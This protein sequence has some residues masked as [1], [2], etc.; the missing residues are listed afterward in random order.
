MEDEAEGV[1]RTFLIADV[2]GYTRYTQ[3]RGDE[4]AAELAAGFARL[5]RE[6]VN[7]GGG[8]LVELRGDEALAVFTSPRQAVRTA[9]QIQRRLRGGEDPGEALPLGIGIGIDTGEAVPVEDGWR[10]KALNVAARLCSVAQPGQIYVTETTGALA[11]GVPGVQL[12]ARKPVRVKGIEQPVRLLEAVPE[13]PLPPLRPLDETASPRRRIAALAVAGTLVA[14]AIAV[15]VLVLGGAGHAGRLATNS[16]GAVDRSGHVHDVVVAGK[17]PSD[18]V[19]DSGALWVADATGHAL[20]RV[21]PRS[22]TVDNYALGDAQPTA[23]AYGDK[24]VWILDGAARRLLYWVPDP[25][26][27]TGSVRVGNGAADVAF[28][29]GAAWV[30]NQVDGTVTRVDAKTLKTRTIDVGVAPVAATWGKGALWV[31]NAGSDSIS[32]VSADGEVETIAVGH[33]PRAIA[34]GGKS[35]WVTSV[36]DHTVWEI[37]PET[38]SARRTIPVDGRPTAIAAD[39]TG[40]WVAAGQSGTVT[41]IDGGGARAHDVGGGPVALAADGDRVWVAAGAPDASHRGGT[42]QIAGLFPVTDQQFGSPGATINPEL[43][44]GLVGLKRVGGPAGT[45]VVPDLATAIPRASYD[46]LTYTF[47]LRNGIRFSDGTAVDP[48]DFVYTF[49]RLFRLH[50]PGAIGEFYGNLAGADA[51][52]QDRSRCDVS[53]MVTADDKAMTVTFHLARRDPD[54][55]A[56]LTFPL[57]WVLPTG[58]PMRRLETELVPSTGPYK[59]AE[60]VAGK[61]MVLTRNPYFHEW[62]HDAQPEGYP[63]RIVITPSTDAVNQVRADKADA[64]SDVVPA[65][66]VPPLARSFPAR[67]HSDTYSKLLYAFLNTRRAPFDNPKARQAVALALDRRA[68]VNRIGGPLLNPVACQVIPP[69]ILGFR[70]YCP[71]SKDPT[72]G[73]WTGPDLAKAQRLV[74]ESGTRGMHVTVWR[75]VVEEPW[76]TFGIELAATLRRV[77]YRV[78]EHVVPGDRF[79]YFG[80]LLDPKTRAQAGPATWAPDVPI[81]SQAVELLFSCRGPNNLSQYCNRR[82]DA[83]MRAAAASE[84]THPGKSAAQWAQ[85][86]RAIV[87]D[88]PVVPVAILGYAQLVSD[89][90][91]NWQAQPQWGPMYGQMWVR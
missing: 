82:L 37:D 80:K 7:A 53:R 87:R 1:L 63:D 44:D 20:L 16:I 23:V 46:G 68:V 78:D 2:R 81:P 45:A 86:D 3:T 22:G 77:G 71:D 55:V 58:T 4:A 17:G 65:D 59:L 12:V 50:D 52:F 62:S 91:G 69:N 15:G 32:R 26:R 13:T 30:P 34:V 89:R 38:L 74:T 29:G 56:K 9:E 19:A 31:A 51:C 47:H 21:D 75:P 42:L 28:G 61:R 79:D 90:V 73:V 49:R 39:A 6:V 57:A 67:L 85:I 88:V 36:A 40:A 5:T 24:V 83:R 14:A 33:D 25:G 18:V 27:T 48:S 41:R 54:F 70:P 10:G 43:G 66:Q 84:Y 11:G 35:L 76:R 64:L 72:T 8:E 60:V